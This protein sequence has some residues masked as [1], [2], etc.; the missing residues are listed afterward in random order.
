MRLTSATNGLMAM[1]AGI[2]F[3]T[4]SAAASDPLPL[5]IQGG[6]KVEWHQVVS[7]PNNDWINDLVP[8][9]N[10]NVLGVGFVNRQDTTPPSDWAAVAV[11]LRPD[12][13]VISD[14]RYGEGAGIDAF[15]SMMEGEGGRRLFAGFTTRIGPGGINGFT[16][17]TG[18]DGKLLN[19]AGRGGE[20]YDRFTDVTQAGDGFVLVGHSQLPN[21]DRRR[22]YLVK[23]DRDGKQVWERIFDG[24]ESW[25]A[26]YVEPSGDGGF[27]IAG[28]VSLGDADS[29]MFVLKTDGEGRELWRKRAGTPD[30]EEINHGLVVR[31][32][33][34]IVLVGYTHAHGAE[35]NDL[36]TA[37]LTRDGDLVRLERWGGAGDDRAILPRLAADGRIWVTGQTASA[38]AGGYDLLLTSIDRNGVFTGEAAIMGGRLDDVGTAV[39]PLNED[40]LVAGYSGNLGRGGEDAFTARVS[41]P[42]VNSGLRFTRSVVTPGRRDPKR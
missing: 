42:S 5:A 17:L 36:V 19:E 26:L 14:R 24:P 32:G 28:G 33:G 10:G 22:V 38:G 34:D 31:P 23:L 20:G 1:L 7:S 18:A 6:A 39:L 2:L 13:T 29:D 37:T 3:A 12:G 9:A 27:I 4:A 16:V 15:W 25:A 35:A 8:L 21:E 30:W 11:E 40:I 41:R